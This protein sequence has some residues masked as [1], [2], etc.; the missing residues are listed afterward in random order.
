[1]QADIEAVLEQVGDVFHKSDLCRALGYEPPRTSLYRALS[2]LERAGIIKLESP[3]MG[4]SA[5][6]YRKV[7]NE[8]GLTAVRNG[9]VPPVRVDP[10]PE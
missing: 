4:R 3:G 8:A 9:N 6:L 1:V 7:R 2:Q 5:G 10:S